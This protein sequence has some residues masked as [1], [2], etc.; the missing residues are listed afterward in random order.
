LNKRDIYMID[1]SFTE[2][3]IPVIQIIIEGGIGSMKCVYE[4]VKNG[5]PVLVLEGTGR[6][7][8][9]IAMGYHLTKD[10]FKYVN[11]YL[12]V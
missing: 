7:A 1:Y 9:F 5:I 6:A 2:V 4:S 3:N 10:N 12:I 11:I 8:D